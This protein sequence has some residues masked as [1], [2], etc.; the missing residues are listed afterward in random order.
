MIDTLTNLLH[1][2]SIWSAAHP[3]ALD[4]VHLSGLLCTFIFFSGHWFNINNLVTGRRLFWMVF[5]ELVLCALIAFVALPYILVNLQSGPGMSFTHYGPVFAL[6]AEFWGF[7]SIVGAWGLYIAWKCIK[8][9]QI[10][11]LHK[12]G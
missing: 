5:G 1:Q 11:V 9:F 8:T 10:D 7:V 6:Y 12:S 3:P 2:L 4:I